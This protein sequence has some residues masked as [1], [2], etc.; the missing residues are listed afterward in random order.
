MPYPDRRKFA[1]NPRSVR[2][3]LLWL[4]DR[5]REL[6]RRPS[7]VLA[8]A[9][10]EGELFV[11]RARLIVTLLILLI[12]VSQSF[13]RPIPR[14][15]L[16]GLTAASF[17]AAAA[18]VAHRFARRTLYRPWIGFLTSAMDVT[19]VSLAL[20]SFLLIDQPHT[21]V[22]SKVVFEVYFVAFLASALRFDPR[23]CAG[24]GLV[25]VV[26]YLALVLFVTSR[27]DLNGP[28]YAP[29]PY[30]MFSWGA[31]FGRIILLAC[32]GV[33]T[34]A[35]TFQARRIQWLAARD[36]LTGLFNRSLFDD[37]LGEAELRARRSGESVAVLVIG[38]DG[39]RKFNRALGVQAGDRALRIAAATVRMCVRRGDLIAR[40]GGDV[41]AVMIPDTN[42]ELATLRAMEVLEKLKATPFTIP[43]QAEPA[44]L[45]FSAG[46]GLFPQDGPDMRAV[47]YAAEARLRSA[48]ETGGGRLVGPA[49]PLARERTVEG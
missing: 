20:A 27:W 10:A 24:T 18:V 37:L 28:Q 45:G 3:W 5:A 44:R 4:G 2:D 39:F 48:K 30:G 46:L 47:L 13:D 17:A 26:E 40:H 9:G 42:V 16:I 21:V 11:A 34:T 32:A 35:L 38:I 29:Y 15:V 7:P 6:A 22:N 33:I 41:T 8:D 31:Q 49:S 23:I 1:G 12:P 14:E 19:L 25:A 43:G 36:P